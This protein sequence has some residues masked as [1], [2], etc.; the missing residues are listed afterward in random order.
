MLEFNSI[1][2]A[3]PIL[4]RYKDIIEQYYKPVNQYLKFVP[5][6]FL[7]ITN[8]QLGTYKV[9]SAESFMEAYQDYLPEGYGCFFVE[10]LPRPEEPK[11]E[12][13][14]VPVPNPPEDGGE[15]VEGA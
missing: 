3:I 12:E 8:E 4:E 11:P 2:K 5:Q 9:V 14:D 10:D 13:P 15:E 6:N 1:I 7:I